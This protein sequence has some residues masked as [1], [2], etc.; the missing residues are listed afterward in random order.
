MISPESCASIL[1]ADPKKADIAANALQVG[2]KKAKELNVIDLIIPEPPGGAH[3]E[4]QRAVE[5]VK[6]ALQKEMQALTAKDIDDIIDARYAK[7]RK[8]GNA[9]ISFA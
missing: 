2:P 1:W 4:P 9:T 6:I 5:M 3:R 8:M 7:F